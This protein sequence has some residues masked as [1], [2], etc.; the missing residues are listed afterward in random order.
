[1][2]GNNRKWLE[3]QYT[4]FGD[5]VLKMRA[6]VAIALSV[7]RV[8]A[9]HYAGAV[10]SGPRGLVALRPNGSG[11]WFERDMETGRVMPP[12]ELE[13]RSGCCLA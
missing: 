4:D 9:Q 7:A 10:V 2:A 8:V 12:V 3:I 1:M 6:P 11:E 13:A 5:K